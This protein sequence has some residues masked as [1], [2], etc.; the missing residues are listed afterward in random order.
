MFNMFD[1]SRAESQTRGAS[2]T[3]TTPSH[4]A[5]VNDAGAGSTASSA[6]GSDSRRR[7]NA[8]PLITIGTV[9]ELH[10]LRDELTNGARGQV[11]DT[12]PRTDGRV[13]VRLTANTRTPETRVVSVKPVNLRVCEAD[14]A[15]ATPRSTPNVATVGGA[16]P[17]AYTR[18]GGRGQRVVAEADSR[19]PWP[20]TRAE[21]ATAARRASQRQRNRRAEGTYIYVL[22][23]TGDE[24]HRAYYYVG[25]TTDPD[26]RL[27]EHVAGLGTGSEWTRR[28]PPTLPHTFDGVTHTLVQVPT[29]EVPGLKE[30][31]VTKEL[32]LK[33][34]IDVVRGGSY[35]A[36]V[37]SDSTMDELKRTLWHADGRCLRCGRTSHFAADCYA[38]TDADG[39]VFVRAPRGGRGGGFR[40]DRS[41]S[42]GGRGGDSGGSGG[43]GAAG[44]A[45]AS[46]AGGSGG[47]SR[48]SNVTRRRSMNDASFDSGLSASRRRSYDAVVDGSRPALRR[49]TSEHFSCSRCGRDSHSIDGCYATVHLNGGRCNDN[50]NE[51]DT[52]IIDC[53][54]PPQPVG[55][56][57]GD[58]SCYRCGRGGHSDRVCSATNHVNG[59]PL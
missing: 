30:D 32:M 37:L 3:T 5:R 10:G 47:G 38:R 53:R 13:L 57:H 58:D 52:I 17:S 46:A 21:P 59:R 45:A 19:R 18:G 44:A 39:Q 34:C 22:Q 56:Y 40:G 31:S 26:R 11:V 7:A 55:G 28:H 41:G 16:L 24:H 25:S 1:Q 49:R 51:N 50:D 4:S 12:A 14:S 48:G 23:L 29:G 27:E 43:G 42:R 6:Q 36:P 9:V 35:A 8:V 2:F 15:S 54:L 20:S 33:Y